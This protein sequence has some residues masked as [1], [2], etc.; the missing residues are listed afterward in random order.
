MTDLGTLPGG[1]HSNAT[2]INDLGQVVGHSST[3]GPGN[4]HAFIYDEVSGM[5]D[6][7]NFGGWNAWANCY[8]SNSL[9]L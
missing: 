8:V 9:S 1:D 6:L 2:A 7:G 5:T 3:N 4:Y